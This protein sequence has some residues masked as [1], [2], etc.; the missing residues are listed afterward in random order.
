MTIQCRV[1]FMATRVTSAPFQSSFV[2]KSYALGQCRSHS[3]VRPTKNPGNSPEGFPATKIFRVQRHQL[4]ATKT[5]TERTIAA[6]KASPI[7]LPSRSGP[8]VFGS[9]YSIICFP[10]ASKVSFRRT[11]AI[12]FK[13]P[14]GYRNNSYRNEPTYLPQGHST[15]SPQ[16]VSAS[17]TYHSSLQPPMAGV[18]NNKRPARGLSAGQEETT[19][20][21]DYQPTLANRQCTSPYHPETPRTPLHR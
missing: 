13:I 8:F 1:G 17:P 9:K 20:P 10:A 12:N 16:S 4:D 14:N 18:R 3:N 11:L 19:T 6:A 21:S 15:N 5:I 2:E 7:T